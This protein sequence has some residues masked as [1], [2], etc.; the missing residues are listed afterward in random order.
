MFR[1]T[2]EFTFEAAHHLP[3]YDGPCKYTHGHSYK[4]QVSVEGPINPTTGMIV[5]FRDLK[6][7]VKTN[8]LHTLDH[9]DL[10][11][12]LAR[13]FPNHMPTAENVLSWIVSR[14]KN[15]FGP[16]SVE[17][18]VAVRLWETSTSYAEWRED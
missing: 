11:T 13:D 4:L 16:S 12:L 6:E 9:N 1:V 18:L 15:C 5:D 3:G 7:I 14:L 2:K 8:V 17:R 10:N